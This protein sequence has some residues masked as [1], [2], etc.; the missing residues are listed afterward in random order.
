M[1][2]TNGISLGLK[3][4][5]S[6]KQVNTN[7]Q[8]TAPF[9]PEVDINCIVYPWYLVLQCT[10]HRLA[11]KVYP[12]EKWNFLE[13]TQATE[14]KFAHLIANRYWYHIIQV[15]GSSQLIFFSQYTAGASAC[16]YQAAARMIKK[17]RP[18]TIRRRRR[19]L[20]NCNW[21][22]QRT[23]PPTWPQHDPLCVWTALRKIVGHS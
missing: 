17:R 10:L 13:T 2:K 4:S 1:T 12:C 6:G 23:R 5:V 8:N 3:R 14:M 7:H 16:L 9:Y 20:P 11:V 19:E 18:R 15:V 22:H 21:K